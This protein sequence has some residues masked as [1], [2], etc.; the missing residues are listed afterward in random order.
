MRGPPPEGRGRDRV[1]V[2]AG[3]CLGVGAQTVGLP[4]LSFA[5]RPLQAGPLVANQRGSELRLHHPASEGPPARGRRLLTFSPPLFKSF[6]GHVL[7]FLY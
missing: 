7:P 3:P 6:P 5:P 1:V 4:P 2:L